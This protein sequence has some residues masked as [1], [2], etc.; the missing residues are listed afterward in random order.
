[1][2]LKF[3]FHVFYFF[4]V[5]EKKQKLITLLFELFEEILVDYWINYFN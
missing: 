1:M 3:E 5:C 4:E 2:K